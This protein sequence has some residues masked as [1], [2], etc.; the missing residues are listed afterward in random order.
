MSWR[1][2]R[3]DDNGNIFLVAGS[4]EEDAARRLAAKLEARAHKQLYFVERAPEA[5]SP[6]SG[7]GPP[8]R[9]H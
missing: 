8:G 2:L 7:G 1:V 6:E 4:L 5:P 9:L 3:Q